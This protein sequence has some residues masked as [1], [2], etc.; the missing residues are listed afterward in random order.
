MKGFGFGSAMQSERVNAMPEEGHREAPKNKNE[1][2]KKKKNPHPRGERKNEIRK[3]EMQCTSCV[4][5]PSTWTDFSRRWYWVPHMYKPH[6]E[7]P[8]Y[9]SGE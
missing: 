8:E 4:G 6:V 2:R 3:G 1:K 9:G 7:M 5:V